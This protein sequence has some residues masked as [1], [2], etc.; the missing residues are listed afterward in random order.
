MENKAPVATL[1]PD[2][3]PPTGAAMLPAREIGRLIEIMAAL[4]DP[5]TG[6]PWDVAQSFATIV[7][8]TIEEAH[9]VA[10][11]V[12]RADMADLRDELG[13][14]LLQVVFHARMAEEAGHFAFGDVVEAITTKMIRRHPH[15]FPS[16]EF[17]DVAAMTPAE[18]KSLWHRIKAVE[19]AEKAAARANP[20]QGGHVDTQAGSVLD[21]VPTS[22]PALTRAWKLQAKAATVGFDWNDPRLVLAKIK[23]EIAEAEAAMDMNDRSHAIEEIG[24]VLFAVANLARHHG[25]D[26]ESALAAANAKFTRRFQFIERTLAARGVAPQDAS[27]DEMEAL[28]QR[29][30]QKEADEPQVAAP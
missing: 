25:A 8:F 1:P 11:A 19:K 9:E 23:E 30:K 5:L 28:W 24:D 29:A 17:G 18:V 27:L 13:D 20:H 4:R 2:I 12:A 14:L 22:L 26:A 21:G 15:V 7:P 3:T 10:D 16:K 6:C